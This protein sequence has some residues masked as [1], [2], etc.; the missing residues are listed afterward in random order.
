[1]SDD[2][3]LLRAVGPQL[4]CDAEVAPDHRDF[5]GDRTEADL[6]RTAELGSAEL[7]SA[8]GVSD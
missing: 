3:L 8:A 4:G 1:M 7:G 2:D 5:S 6:F